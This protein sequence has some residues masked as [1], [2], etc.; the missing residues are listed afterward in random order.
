[1]KNW[2]TVATVFLTG[3]FGALGAKGLIDPM[4]AATAGTL[5]ASAITWIAHRLQP[6]TP[7]EKKS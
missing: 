2:P 3:G 4:L 1:M 7:A 5:V 6:P